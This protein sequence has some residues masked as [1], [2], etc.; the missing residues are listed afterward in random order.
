M[1]AKSSVVLLVC[2]VIA[3]CLKNITLNEFAILFDACIYIFICILY[4]V[5]SRNRENHLK[6]SASAVQNTPSYS[7][8]FI[9]NFL[10]IILQFLL[11]QAWSYKKTH[12]WLFYIYAW[13]FQCFRKK[14]KYINN[15]ILH[16]QVGV[17]EWHQKIPFAR[18]P[19]VHV[20]LEN[21]K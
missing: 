21:K 3:N 4:I 8:N 19:L 10:I 7:N 15:K 2:D 16:A 9:R 20:L 5:A 17:C 13:E 1:V 12:M 14:N 11:I 18:D 6:V